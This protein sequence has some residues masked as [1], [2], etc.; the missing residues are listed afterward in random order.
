[1]PRQYRRTM[2]V[3]S[4]CAV[5]SIPASTV[6]A[7]PSPQSPST[8]NW[9]RNV[10]LA[11]SGPSVAG[12]W[13]A[14]MQYRRIGAPSAPTQTNL[15]TEILPPTRSLRATYA[16]SKFRHVIGTVI[17]GAIRIRARDLDRERGVGSRGRCL[18]KRSRR[19]RGRRVGRT[20]GNRDRAGTIIVGWGPDDPGSVH[21]SIA[22]TDP[23]V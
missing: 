13:L 11:L 14:T 9:R 19:A 18:D 16:F 22:L 8:G 5:D 12:P 3:A 1:M 23:N 6:T 2:R 20:H 4:P 10:T 21:I 15:E 7:S 17:L